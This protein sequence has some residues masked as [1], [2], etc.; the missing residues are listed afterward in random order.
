MAKLWACV[1]CLYG[2]L[3]S[4][5]GFFFLC[6]RSPLFCH[7]IHCC[8]FFQLCRQTKFTLIR[9][10]F[11]LIHHKT[12]PHYN[13]S[14]GYVVV[15]V[16][17]DGAATPSSRLFNNVVNAIRL[18]FFLTLFFSL[19]HRFWYTHFG[20]PSLFCLLDYSHCSLSPRFAFV[21]CTAFIYFEF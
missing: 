17:G 14:S 5:S 4:F 16:G 10:V 6:L 18:C 13:L 12:L 20:L 11:A 15:V 7:A 1:I 8:F 9:N 2:V 3:V 19:C 21:P